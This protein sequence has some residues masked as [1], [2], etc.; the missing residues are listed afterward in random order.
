M[1][2]PKPYREKAPYLAVQADDCWQ[3]IFTF[4][5]RP[6]KVADFDCQ[7]IAERHMRSL[8]KQ[9]WL[10]DNARMAT[11]LILLHASQTSA[12]QCALVS[13]ASFWKKLKA[14]LRPRQHTDLG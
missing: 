3:V 14:A 1:Y 10:E 8:N 4:T 5:N 12:A 11:R 6:Y 9:W 13:P 2:F 7:E